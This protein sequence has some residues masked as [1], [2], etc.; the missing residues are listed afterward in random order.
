MDEQHTGDSARSTR[1][2][3]WSDAMRAKVDALAD[4]HSDTPVVGLGVAMYQ[5]D[6][7]GAGAVVGSAIAFR[8]FLFFV[9]MLLFVVGIAGF[10]S[11]LVTAGEATQATGISGGLADQIR[12]AFNQPGATR[13]AATL[14]GLIG[15]LIAGRSLSKALVAA[16][17]VAWR[18]PRI[19]RASMRTVGMIAGLIFGM[20]LITVLVNRVRDDYG[21]GVASVS[22][23]PAFIVYAVAWLTIS[24]MLPRGTDDPGAFI[25]GALLVAATITSMQA[26][27]EFYLPSKLSHASELYGAI[28]T[29]VVTLGWFFFL[30]RG[31]SIAMQL[32]AV[33]YER[34]GSVSTV[35]FS[36]PVLRTLPRRSERIR[37]FFDLEV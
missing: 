25:P 31:I 7:D 6:R 30:G 36:L 24:M 33:L 19:D 20:A 35:V 32:N 13:W 10:V 5:R 14:F 37:A 4:R 3:R 2:R 16:N 22:F 8:L 28:G 34:Y 21:L 26:I 23:L 11:R 9:P 18:L 29:T 12:T 17:S 1:I 27:S 15:I